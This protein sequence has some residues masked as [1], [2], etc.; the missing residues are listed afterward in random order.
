MTYKLV[1]PFR[2]RS[3]VHRKHCVKHLPS[4]SP[5]S[6]DCIHRLSS[7]IRQL[8]YYGFERLSDLRRRKSGPMTDP[9]HILFVHPSR[10]FV[11]GDASKLDRILRKTRKASRQQ[12]L[13]STGSDGWP[14]HPSP[15][16]GQASLVPAPE[17]R[18]VRSSPTRP[19]YMPHAYSD[20]TPR[21]AGI[22]YSASH[23]PPGLQRS[24]SSPGVPMETPRTPR[25][26]SRGPRR[27]SWVPVSQHQQYK[28][29]MYAPAPHSD[30]P[31]YVIQRA[32]APVD[33][34]YSRHYSANA[35][36]S[37]Y[38][39]AYEYQEPMMEYAPQHHQ[40]RVQH[41]HIAPHE[42]VSPHELI[43]APR[44]QMVPDSPLQRPVASTSWSAPR[45]AQHP[46]SSPVRPS[47]Q[48]P[49]PSFE[50]G[51]FAPHQPALQQP[52]PL[53]WP[54]YDEGVGKMEFVD[55]SPEMLNVPLPSSPP[56][57]S[58]LI[59]YANFESPYDQGQ[60]FFPG[61]TQIWVH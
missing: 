51:V 49:S 38:E 34:G 57:S 18:F 39:Q 20:I 44:W 45:T 61:N 31:A 55:A 48:R 36:E 41:E 14:E 53:E 50:H 60:S 25:Q 22:Y 19:S 40:P 10:C 29:V 9:E 3:S 8:N 13:N 24:A 2:Q 59:N 30:G 23:S 26:M 47:Y 15:Y 12:R 33:T 42:H 27:S 4:E 37:P 21:S 6:A 52:E 54:E 56:T 16:G 58:G 5:P 7:F 35:Y 46:P 1:K 11:R 28:Q 32:H 43:G 17:P